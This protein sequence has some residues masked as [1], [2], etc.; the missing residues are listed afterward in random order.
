MVGLGWGWQ[1]KPKVI[2]K[3]FQ[4]PFSLSSLIQLNY[5]ACSNNFSNLKIYKH[6]MGQ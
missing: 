4:F 5:C 6:L 1:Q 2:R 3:K